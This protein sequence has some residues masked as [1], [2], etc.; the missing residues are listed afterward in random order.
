MVSKKLELITPSPRSNDQA[1]KDQAL[2]DDVDQDKD[3]NERTKLIQKEGVE[4]VCSIEQS[5]MK[6]V[7]MFL[8]SRYFRE[9]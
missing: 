2:D 8:L 7:L 6:V 3:V 5:D 1:D 4:L 9:V